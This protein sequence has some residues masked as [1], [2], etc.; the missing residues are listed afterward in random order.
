MSNRW[1]KNDVHLVTLTVTDEPSDRPN[2]DARKEVQAE[3]SEVAGKEGRGEGEEA[4][5]QEM[6]TVEGDVVDT[7]G[8]QRGGACSFHT[9][10]TPAGQDKVELTAQQVAALRLQLEQQLGSW[11]QVRQ[12]HKYCITFCLLLLYLYNF[13]QI[14]QKHWLFIS[15]CFLLFFSLT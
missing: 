6:V 8:P 9:L 7:Q 10:D 14:R 13:A 11:K 1:I 15:C 12:I 3:R 5:E 2:A 4:G